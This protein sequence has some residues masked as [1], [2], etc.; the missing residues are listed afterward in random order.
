MLIRKLS[1]F[2]VASFLSISANAIV[3]DIHY[4]GVVK[5][6]V[7]V[8][9]GYNI[10]DAVSGSLKID[11]SKSFGDSMPFETMA[12]YASASNEHNFISGHFNTDIGN[13]WD[14]V[15]VYNNS[16][17][18]DLS[19]YGDSAQIIDATVED[20][21]DPTGSKFNSIQHSLAFNDLS[22]LDS[23]KLE[24]FKSL[25]IFDLNLS[26]SQGAFVSSQTII[27][28]PSNYE[29]IYEF[30]IFD[31]LSFDV[32][33]SKVSEPNAIFLLLF[34]L[35]ALFSRRKFTLGQL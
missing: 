19:Y 28:S 26:Y 14:K 31:Y 30:A 18:D 34:G 7:G 10:G 29:N 16:Y 13:A 32:S 25:N 33:V 8:G 24:Y 27:H 20:T 22:V 3:I 21:N 17:N 12:H 23:D 15:Y 35:I 1:I 9:L 6:L 11:T 5:Q 4:T 2:F